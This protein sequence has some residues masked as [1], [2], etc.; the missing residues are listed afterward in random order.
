MQ[1]LSWQFIH[2]VLSI[3]FIALILRIIRSNFLR[4][5]KILRIALIVFI[6]LLLMNSVGAFLAIT[7]HY[8]SLNL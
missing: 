2:L 5:K 6:G 4:D 1:I 7:I 3:V 8:L